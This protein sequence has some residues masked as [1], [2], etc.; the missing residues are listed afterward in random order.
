M[1]IQHG[2]NTVTLPLARLPINGTADN[3][4]IPNPFGIDV[5]ITDAFVVVN[6]VAA[7]AC[8]LDIG[9]AANSSTNNDTL[10]DGL[11]VRTA[12]GT[13]ESRN[14]TDNGA[15]GGVNRRW[16]ATGYV[17]A[18]RAS[19]AIAGLSAVLVLRVIPAQ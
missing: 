8:T 2:Q 19:G 14:D 5:I 6:T 10:F 9:P 12:T 13:F 15:N 16:T 1:A 3:W 18:R 17:N 7:A 11:D 4:N